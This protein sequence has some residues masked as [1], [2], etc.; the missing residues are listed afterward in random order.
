MEEGAASAKKVE[1]K[2]GA[3][4]AEKR[5]GK[6]GNECRKRRREGSKAG[7]QISINY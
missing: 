4:S 7:Y 5:G 1:G 2:E 6:G 3:S